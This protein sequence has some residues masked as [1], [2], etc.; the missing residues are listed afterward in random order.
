MSICAVSLW[1]NLELE[2]NIISV[3][4]DLNLFWRTFDFHFT[5]ILTIIKLCAE[6]KIMRI[7]KRFK[8][9]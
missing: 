6:R 3:V 9:I 8:I 2:I 4:T 7:F 1:E 5:L